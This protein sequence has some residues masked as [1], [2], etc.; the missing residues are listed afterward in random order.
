M[1][2]RR[3]VGRGGRAVILL[4]MSLGSGCAGLATP[5]PPTYTQAELA[6]ICQRNGGWWHDDS[7]MGG[8]CEYEGPMP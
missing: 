3:R 8:F 7:L 5:H 1:T 4:A 6:A 2:A